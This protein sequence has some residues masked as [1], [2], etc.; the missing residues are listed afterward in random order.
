MLIDTF[1]VVNTQTV[2][3]RQRHWEGF[4]NGVIGETLADEGA[5]AEELRYGVRYTDSLGALLENMGPAPSEA[6]EE[7][8]KEGEEE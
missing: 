2:K 7:V 1:A 4:W 6:V 5:T 3:P 8:M